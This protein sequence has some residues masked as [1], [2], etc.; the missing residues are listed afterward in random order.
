MNSN[1]PIHEHILVTGGAGFIGSAILRYA[2]KRYPETHFY[3]LDALTYAG[4][5]ENLSPIEGYDNYHFIQGD[6]SDYDF[7]L[8]LLREYHF[9]GVINFAAESHV[10]RSIKDP[11]IFM[12]NNVRGCVSLLRA[13]TKVWSREGGYEGKRFY[14]ISTDEV[15]GSLGPNDAPFTE[16]TPYMPHSP[17]AASKAACDHFVRAFH[18]TYGLPTLI[19]NCSNN[20]GP[21]QHPEKLIPLFINNI[22]EGRELPVYGDGKQVRDWLYVDDHAAAIDLIYHEGRV[23]ETYNIGGRCERENIEVIHTLIRLVDEALGRPTGSSEGLIRHVTD[24]PGHDVRYAIDP[25]KLETELG[26]RPQY[27][28]EQ[29]M[30][31]TVTWYL[32]HEEWLNHVTTGAYRSYYEDMYSRR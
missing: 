13:A 28:F 25:T 22:K 15:Y 1:H 9:D 3:N 20:Y 17:Y 8:S 6:I 16:K 14:Q 12:K 31:K 7:V 26:W 18:D 19:S 2:V 24:R 21:Y 4:N 32:E 11:G 30:R 27:D 29:G 23:G 5:L 10:D